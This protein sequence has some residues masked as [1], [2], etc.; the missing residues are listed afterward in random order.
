MKW[1]LSPIR[2]GDAKTSSERFR[3]IGSAGR[4]RRKAVICNACNA[5]FMQAARRLFACDLANP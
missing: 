4:N 1:L 3:T 5:L 2:Q